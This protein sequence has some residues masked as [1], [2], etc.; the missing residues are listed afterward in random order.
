MR[1]LTVILTSLLLI[2]ESVALCEPLPTQPF[3]SLEAMEVY[4][5][6]VMPDQW[7]TLDSWTCRRGVLFLSVVGLLA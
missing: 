5:Q 3:K 2:I 1:T 6:E 7:R 4:S